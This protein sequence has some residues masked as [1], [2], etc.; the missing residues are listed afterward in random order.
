MRQEDEMCIRDSNRRAG[1]LAG[2]KPDKTGLL[3]L[4][5]KGKDLPTTAQQTLPYREMYRLSLIHI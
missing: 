2:K 3:G 1:K 5:T 4:L